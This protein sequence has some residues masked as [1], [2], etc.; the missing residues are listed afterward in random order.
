MPAPD[1]ASVGGDSLDRHPRAGGGDSTAGSEIT[2]WR[3]H[4]GS[5]TLQLP[6]QLPDQS[7]QGR[8]RAL[9]HQPSDNGAARE[10]DVEPVHLNAGLVEL[11][12][13]SCATISLDD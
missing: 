13:R 7:G 9:M 11:I 6:N 3:K 10:I 12:C 8:G 5:T 4:R 2:P 1:D